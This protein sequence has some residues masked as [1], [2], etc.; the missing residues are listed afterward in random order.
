MKLPEIEYGGSVERTSDDIGRLDEAQ[1]RA[2]GVVAEGLTRYGME[3]VK[4]ETQAAA[5]DLAAGL[6]E[7]EAALMSRRYVSTQDL[8]DAL[9]ADFES[10]PPELK[11][12]T[13]T[14]A[15]DIPSGQMV[16]V[17]RND[18]P[19]WE[20]AGAIFDARAKRLREAAGKRIGASGWRAEFDAKAQ[21]EI[22]ARKVKLAHSQLQ[23]MDQDLRARQLGVVDTLT[24]ARS[25]GQAAAA[26]AGSDI[27]TPAEKE[28]LQGQVDHARQLQPLE[29]RL[30]LGVSSAADVLEVGKLVGRLESG[31]GLDRLEDKERIEW[32]RRLE[33][34][35]KEFEH[36]A[37]T[38]ADAQFKAADEAAW[39][40]VLGA[41]RQA[42]GRPLAMSL[43]PDPGAISSDAQRALIAFVEKTRDGGEVKTD[44]TL[45]AGL[46]RQAMTDPAAFKNVDLT[47]FLGR[48]SVPHFTHFAD[49]QRTLRAGDDVKYQGFVGAQEET[50]RHLL[51]AGFHVAGKDAE[52]DAL[53]VG[54]VHSVVNT[55]LF[56]ATME[57]KRELTLDER[58]PL[59]ARV[60]AR[61]VK[62]QGWLGRATVESLGIDPP[63][64]APLRNAATLLGRPQ[65]AEGLRKLQ[66]EYSAAEGAIE[67]AWRR[68]STKALTPMQAAAVFTLMRRDQAAI[69]AAL[70][71]AGK[72]LDDSYRAA[73][74][75]EA[76]LRG[77]R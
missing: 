17:D 56:R 47:Q 10:L 32:K 40:K 36:G 2:A 58:D 37:R 34:E 49:L 6:A 35:V 38:A 54:H 19:V 72:P 12:R 41:Y 45:Y 75:V 65:N 61:E 50:N 39:N 74:A 8:R 53:A 16:D 62:R 14:Q 9:G 29:D 27:F 57:K 28:K 24:R 73:A 1:R 70:T 42:G 48:L 66:G 5:A 21:E 60:V 44:L 63:L 15:L 13:R 71:R 11:A 22:Q 52:K 64:V 4:T 51:G 7:T 55:E 31:E 69:D 59:I 33:A 30:L 23:A 43:V 46:T 77:A 18:I 68:R 67:A 20:V 26:I 76:I 3:L 25:F